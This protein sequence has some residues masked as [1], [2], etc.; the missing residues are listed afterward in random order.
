M[1]FIIFK[2][3]KIKKNDRKESLN[4]VKKEEKSSFFVAI[5]LG[6]GGYNRCIKYNKE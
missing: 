2:N 5:F 1:Y 3:P 6:G 4:D